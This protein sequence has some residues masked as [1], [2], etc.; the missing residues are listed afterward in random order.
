MWRYDVSWCIQAT[1]N[2]LVLVEHK[3]QGE[4]CGEKLE[5][6]TGAAALSWV[7]KVHFGGYIGLNEARGWENS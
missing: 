6:K 7:K 3:E 5:T 4:G 1:T 2:P